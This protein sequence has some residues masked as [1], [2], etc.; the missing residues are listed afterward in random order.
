MS[1]QLELPL[2]VRDEVPKRQLIP[3]SGGGMREL[4]IPTVLDRF[5]QQ[6]LLQVLQSDLDGSFSRHSYGFR[7]GRSAHEAVCA[8]QRFV[9]QG[10][11]WVV[12]VDLEKLRRG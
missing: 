1:G 6:A 8:A 12:D 10:R 3:K 9:Q 11:R 5:I 2:E 4:G 7:P